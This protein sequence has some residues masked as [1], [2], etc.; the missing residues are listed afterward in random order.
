MADPETVMAK[1]SIKVK[2]TVKTVS[3]N[4][5]PKCHCKNCPS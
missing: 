1:F 2:S 4:I 3:G 5:L